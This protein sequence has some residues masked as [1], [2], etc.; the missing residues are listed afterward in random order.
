MRGCNLGTTGDCVEGQLMMGG[1][2]AVSP[3][4]WVMWLPQRL[5]E[6]AGGAEHAPAC[7]GENRGQATGC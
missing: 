2:E 7:G 6:P 1:L 5:P 3:A 4:R